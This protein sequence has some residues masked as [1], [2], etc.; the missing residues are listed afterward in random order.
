[1]DFY[2][3]FKKST[4]NITLNNRFRGFNTVVTHEEFISQD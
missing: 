4:C 2:S 1:M 3:S